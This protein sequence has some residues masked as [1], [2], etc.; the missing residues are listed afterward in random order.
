MDRIIVMTKEKYI[1]SLTDRGYE[2]V[3]EDRI[4]LGT[5]TFIINEGDIKTDV[6]MQH[7]F[8]L[9]ILENESDLNLVPNPWK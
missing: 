7:T 2:L 4:K 5:I 1:K 8:W 6:G 9:T 3:D